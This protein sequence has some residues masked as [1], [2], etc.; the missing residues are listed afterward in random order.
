MAQE[1]DRA[2]TAR[3][4]VAAA[5]QQRVSSASADHARRTEIAVSRPAM[6]HAVMRRDAVVIRFDTAARGDAKARRCEGAEVRGDAGRCGATRSVRGDAGRCGA[7]RSVRG[8]AVQREACGAMRCN[9]KRARDAAEAARETMR[10]VCPAAA[11]A[12]VGRELIASH[13][14][15][16]DGK[17]P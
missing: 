11:N 4:D 1:T 13:H 17:R 5:R 8:D 14:F 10:V 12:C 6:R 2:R 3:A 16:V 15:E 9:A 7:T